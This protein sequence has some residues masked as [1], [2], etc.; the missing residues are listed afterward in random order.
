MPFLAHPSLTP[1]A[2]CTQMTTGTPISG[3]P[4]H[5]VQYC[6]PQS[7]EFPCAEICLKVTQSLTQMKESRG[8]EAE[9]DPCLNICTHQTICQFSPPTHGKESR[10]KGREKPFRAP[11]LTAV[12]EGAA[13]DDVWQQASWGAARGTMHEAIFTVTAEK[14]P[15][16]LLKFSTPI[17][18]F[19]TTHPPCSV[20]SSQ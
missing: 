15:H 7:R 13:E 2:R 3:I 14:T 1:A 8:C 9:P 5:T 20:R 18:P 10:Q 16:L 4:S 11:V 12:R 19:L 17:A 6:L